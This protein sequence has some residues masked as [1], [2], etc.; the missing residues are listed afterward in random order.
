MISISIDLVSS[1]P[2]SDSYKSSLLNLAF[3]ADALNLLYR[4]HKRLRQVR[5]PVAT[6]A[7]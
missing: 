1:Y 5:K 2:F 3:V 7:T 6:Q 4:L